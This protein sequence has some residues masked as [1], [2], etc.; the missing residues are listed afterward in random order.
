MRR[1]N[2]MTEGLSSSTRSIFLAAKGIKFSEL[3]GPMGG[4]IT[5]V[6]QAK[7]IYGLSDHVGLR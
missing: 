7:A 5:P 2:I 6:L 3:P 4:T 1:K